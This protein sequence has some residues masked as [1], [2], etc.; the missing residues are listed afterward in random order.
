MLRF[1]SM[2]RLMKRKHFSKYFS[3]LLWRKMALR[4]VYNKLRQETKNLELILNRGTFFYEYKFK[5]HTFLCIIFQCSQ[6]THFLYVYSISKNNWD[7]WLWIEI[8]AI[9]I[10]D[11][12]F[13]VFYVGISFWYWNLCYYVSF[14]FVLTCEAK[15]RLGV[16]Y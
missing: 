10:H 8:F 2:I 14:Y 9:I 1:A 5:G 7:C 4:N 3:A 13:Y 15:I 16:T 6:I 12:G 11:N